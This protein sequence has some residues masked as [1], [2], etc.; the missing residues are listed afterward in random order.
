LIDASIPLCQDDGNNVL[1]V[2]ETSISI[3]ELNWALQQAFI[4]P[5]CPPGQLLTTNSTCQYPALSSDI[6]Q[7]CTELGGEPV[8]ASAPDD[9]IPYND[10]DPLCGATNANQLWCVDPSVDTSNSLSSVYEGYDMA[11]DQFGDECVVDGSNCDMGNLS[12]T[13]STVSALCGFLDGSILGGCGTANGAGD[14]GDGTQRRSSTAV[15][16]GDASAMLTPRK[17]D[18]GNDD[19]SEGSDKK[20]WWWW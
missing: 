7:N 1:I 5:A 6:A 14:G 16:E 15:G 20:R 3:P 17:G 4:E 12:A 10:V 13:W 8:C 9:W 19:G 11:V 2:I 18:D